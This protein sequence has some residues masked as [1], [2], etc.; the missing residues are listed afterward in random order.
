MHSAGNGQKRMD[1]RQQR[2]ADAAHEHRHKKAARGDEGNKRRDC[3]E[4]HH[5]V[6]AEVQHTGALVHDLAQRRQEQRACPARPQRSA[7]HE[8]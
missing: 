1:E 5:A 6:K 7:W 3:A 8:G 2:G 4:E